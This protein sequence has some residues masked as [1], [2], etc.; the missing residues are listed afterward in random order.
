MANTTNFNWETPDDTDLVK[1]GA[2]AIRTL[3]GAID[4]SLV[5]L[6]GGTTDQVL[7]KNSDTDMDFKWV[8]D[9]SGIPATIF[10]A[11]GDL[12]AASAADTA[13]RLAVGTN[14][15]VLTADSGETTGMK[16]AASA[17]GLSLISTTTFSAVASQSI[18]DVFSSTYTNY[19]LILEIR[20]TTAAQTT[21]R[22]R[23]S[24]SDNTASNYS[25]AQLNPG[26]AFGATGTGSSWQVMR[27]DNGEG[28]VAFIELG[29]PFATQRTTFANLSSGRDDTIAN[30]SMIIGQMTVNTSYTGFT[31]FPQSGNITGSA[32]VYGYNI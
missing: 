32:S 26:N 4:T 10:D 28:G 16:W 19:K 13:A 1:D 11:K 29:N 9:A 21:L 17:G 24:G 6:K 5:D 30:P 22:M 8:A 23:V 27:T 7:A 31:I 15:Q 20:G 12:I 3:A 2:L 18:N 14:G 25:A